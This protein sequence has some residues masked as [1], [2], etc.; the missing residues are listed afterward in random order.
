MRSPASTIAT[1]PSHCEADKVGQL[2]ENLAKE[3]DDEV[4]LL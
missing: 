3:G 1:T 4:G 2:R